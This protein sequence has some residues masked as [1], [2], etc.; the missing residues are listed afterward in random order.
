[1]IR[2]AGMRGEKKG[3]IR[4]EGGGEKERSRSSGESLFGTGQIRS[5]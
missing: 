3:E 5:N 1:V 4:R 2:L